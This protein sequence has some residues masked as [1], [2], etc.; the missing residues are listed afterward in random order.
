MRLW[1]RLRRAVRAVAAVGAGSVT[2][3]CMADLGAAV[4]R[5][6]LLLCVLVLVAFSVRRPMRGG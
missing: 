4:V 1:E 2:G 3:V 6:L 5:S